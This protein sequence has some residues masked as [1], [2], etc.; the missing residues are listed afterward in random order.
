MLLCCALSILNYFTLTST[1]SFHCANPRTNPWNFHKKTLRIGDFEKWPFLSRPFWI[2][3]CFIPVKI[4][5]KLCVRMDGTQILWLWWFTAKTQSP[6]T[7][8]PAVYV[9]RPNHHGMKL[10]LSGKVFHMPLCSYENKNI[11]NIKKTCQKATAY[12]KLSWEL[13]FHS[14]MIWHI[15]T[16]N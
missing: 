16:A 11:K 15:S 10:W 7:F 12:K 2:F 13:Q 6:Q 3:F 5:H 9:A 14:A 8:Q 1:N 4:C